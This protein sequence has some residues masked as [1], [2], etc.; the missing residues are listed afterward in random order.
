MEHPHN[1]IVV[2]LVADYYIDRAHFSGIIIKAVVDKLKVDLNDLKAILESTIAEQKLL[3][4]PEPILRCGIP[5]LE[6]QHEYLSSDDLQ[7]MYLYPTKNTTSSKLEA[8]QMYLDRPYSKMLAEVTPRLHLCHFDY[9]VLLPYFDD[10]RFHIKDDGTSAYICVDNNTDLIEEEHALI[11]HF[12]YSYDNSGRKYIAVPLIYLHD[13]TPTLQRR[14]QTYE[15]KGD[16]QVDKDFFDRHILGEWGGTPTI[17]DAFLEEIKQINIICKLASEPQFFLKEYERS[18]ITTFRRFFKPTLEY[19]NE[20]AM[21]LDKLL[22]DN[23]NYDFFKKYMNTKDEYG[24]T[25]GTIVLLER[26]FK[27][28]FTPATKSDSE[29]I[30]ELIS[31]LR[32][33]RQERQAR[34][35]KIINNSYDPSFL[36]KQKE[37]MSKAYMALKLL[38]TALSGHCLVKTYGAPEWLEMAQF[39]L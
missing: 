3:V 5:N 14:W 9:A 35:H 32:H 27:N 19:Y 17:F 1:E 34:A 29:L 12:G 18:Q 7:N 26:W 25:I 39:K 22:S 33:I 28:N 23:M 2:N 8:E 38:R 13:L 37:L 4:F 16:I 36:E 30:D 6:E 11:Q 31:T 15:R 20:L 10:P 24:K 21:D